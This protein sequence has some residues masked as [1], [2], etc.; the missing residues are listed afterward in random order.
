[1]I[2]RPALPSEQAIGHAPAPVDVLSGNLLE[3]MPELCLLDVD[4]LA[5]MALDAAVLPNHAAGLAL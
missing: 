5:G 1:M 4:N 3:T 2:D